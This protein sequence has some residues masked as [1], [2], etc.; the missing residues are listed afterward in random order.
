MQCVL[1]LS[2]LMSTAG[3][4]ARQLFI[5]MA[6]D[7][8]RRLQSLHAFSS[9]LDVSG[10]LNFTDFTVPVSAFLLFSYHKCSHLAQDASAKPR[11]I[12]AGKIMFADFISWPVSYSMLL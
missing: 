1:K 10:G 5:P 7:G 9:L 2:Y 12:P 6:V 11:A 8:H 4:E 3:Q